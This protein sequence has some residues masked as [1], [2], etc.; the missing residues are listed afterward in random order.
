MSS[1]EFRQAWA[2]HDVQAPWSKPVQIDHPQVGELRLNLSKLEF[3]GLPLIVYHPVP[4]SRDAARL[5]L[6]V[7][8]VA[9]GGKVRLP[10]A[11][12]VGDRLADRDGRLP[13]GGRL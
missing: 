4:G 9:S 3:D 5:A 12:R 13:A 2:R 11:D 7:S 10:P 6:L 8:L 1:V